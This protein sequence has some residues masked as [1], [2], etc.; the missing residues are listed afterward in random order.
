MKRLLL[1]FIFIT[2]SIATQTVAE[3]SNIER[4]WRFGDFKDINNTK[5]KTKKTAEDLLAEIL[6]VQKK[7]LKVQNKILKILEEQFNPKPKEIVINGK[8]CIENSSA[9]CFNFPVIAE[10][11]RIPVL[12]NWLKNPT[13]ENAAKWQ[14]WLSKYMSQVLNIGMSNVQAIT[15]FGD[16]Y[17]KHHFLT[18]GFIDATGYNKAL[19]A[20]TNSMVLKKYLSKK[21]QIYIFLGYQSDIDAI[22][23]PTLSEF[24]NKFSNDI[25]IAVIYLN[26]DIQTKLKN[27]YSFVLKNPIKRKNLISILDTNKNVFYGEKYFKHFGIY[28]TPSIVVRNLK[29]NKSQII[30][31]G[32]STMQTIIDNIIEYAKLNKLIPFN[33]M[34]NHKEFNVDPNNKWLKE[35]LKNIYQYDLNLTGNTYNYFNEEKK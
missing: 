18:N 32:K 20:K 24:Y 9:E 10:A 31:T 3:K 17:Y 16:K 29:T 21:I 7:Q 5:K 33:Y 25:E 23:I 28:A 12:K 11:K 35:K 19:E 4:G 14:A 26:K 1:V 22:S 6:E 27:I 15:Q 34:S 8:K 30:Q 2:T 13:I